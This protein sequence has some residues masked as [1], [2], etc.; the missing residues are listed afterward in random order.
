MPYS[1]TIARA[2][3][4]ACSMS[5]TAP[6]VGSRNTSSSAARPPIAKTS[7]AIIS[8]RVISPLVVLGHR[9]GMAASAAAGQDGDLVD[10]LD[11]GHR[12]RRQGVTT[13]VVGGDLLLQLADDPALAARAADHAVDGLLQRGGAGDD[14]AVLPRGQQ[15]GLIDDVGQI[16]AGHADRALGQAIQVGIGRE[17]LALGVHP[18]HGLA[19]GEVR[20]GHRDLPV[21]AAG[22]SSAGSRMSGRLVAIRMTP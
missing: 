16:G 17:R 8:E 7:R 2:I 14:G 18:Q 12:P 15:G 6:V 22:R 10:R 5:D 21:E 3:L 19:A 20:R 4:V 13:L 1:V 11:V 9:H